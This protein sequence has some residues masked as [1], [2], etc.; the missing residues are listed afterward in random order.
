MLVEF[1]ERLNKIEGKVDRIRDGVTVQQVNE[2]KHRVKLQEMGRLLSGK[3]EDALKRIKEHDPKE[4]GYEL[5]SAL[6]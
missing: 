5:A 4:M 3:P 2:Q 1:Y 6:I